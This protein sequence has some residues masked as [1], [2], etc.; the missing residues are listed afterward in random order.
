MPLS[1]AVAWRLQMPQP[2]AVPLWRCAAGCD[3]IVTNADS[4]CLSCTL[5]TLAAQL[6]PSA[7]VPHLRLVRGEVL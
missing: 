2:N 5:L 7:P 1:L 6:P 4:V 3:A